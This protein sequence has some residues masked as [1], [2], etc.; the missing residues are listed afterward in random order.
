MVLSFAV[1]LGAPLPEATAPGAKVGGGIGLP[2]L[3]LM[4]LA[5]LLVCELPGSGR[6]FAKCCGVTRS[7]CCI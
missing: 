5:L 2:G 4:L 1:V 3:A 7:I 6:G